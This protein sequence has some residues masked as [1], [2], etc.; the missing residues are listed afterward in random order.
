M[1]ALRPQRAPS[2]PSTAAPLASIDPQHFLHDAIFSPVPT[3]DFTHHIVNKFRDGVYE[4]PDP[5]AVGLRV[6]GAARCFDGRTSRGLQGVNLEEVKCPEKMFWAAALWEEIFFQ[7]HAPHLA[8]D[9]QASAECL[10]EG[11]RGNLFMMSRVSGM[12]SGRAWLLNSSLL[13]SL[14]TLWSLPS[15]MLGGIVVVRGEGMG[16]VDVLCGVLCRMCGRGGLILVCFFAVVCVALSLY[17][18]NEFA[19]LRVFESQKSPFTTKIAG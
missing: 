3:C 12:K 7:E 13:L 16:G 4:H 14:S 19:I 9:E 2:S 6:D 18:G 15:S 10:T 1:N 11:S 8:H 17:R 5:L